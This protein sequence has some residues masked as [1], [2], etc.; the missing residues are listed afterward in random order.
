MSHP[1]DF[2]LHLQLVHTVEVETLSA[3]NM[4][5]NPH[6]ATI[7]KKAGMFSSS[8]LSLLYA[9]CGFLGKL[10]AESVSTSSVWT[11]CE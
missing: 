2:G 4:P 9:L 8:S 6:E 10:C 7:T 11:S 1:I 5:R 3:H